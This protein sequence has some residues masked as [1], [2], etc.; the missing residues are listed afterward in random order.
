MRSVLLTSF[1]LLASASISL[2]APPPYVG[3]GAFTLPTGSTA[4]DDAADG[5][6]VCIT[7]A[8]AILRQSSI[9]GAIYTP[10]GSLPAGAVPSYGAGFLR[11]SPDG[12][13]LAIGDNG[14]ANH[15]FIVPLASLNTSGP[16]SPQSIPVANFDGAWADNSTLYISGSPDFSTPP[17]LFRVN[18]T[19]STAAQVV[20]NIGDG[21]G[22]VAIRAGRVYTA[23][24]YDN[25]GLLDGQVRSFDLSTLNAA[26]A[27]VLFSTG[28]LATQAS[29]GNTLD[30]DGA[31]GGGADDIIVAGFGG[32]TLVDL[33]TAQRY[34]LPGLSS[35][36]FYSALFNDSTGEILVRDFGSQTVL[37]FAVPGPACTP[38]LALAALFATRRR[39]HA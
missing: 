13:N 27:P 4:F 31:G 7:E 2:A 21:S 23:I 5:R 34:D 39:R 18:L 8:G 16:T 22:G 14:A 17:G 20:S 36:G 10:L 35:T 3:V 15:T 6:L 38:M 29:T 24:G 26:P 33:A 32:V 28:L 12:A 1:G 30:F 25:G 37:R 19:T 9:N 11:I